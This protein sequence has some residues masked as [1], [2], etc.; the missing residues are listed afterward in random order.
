MHEVKI[1]VKVRKTRWEVI[2][3][4]GHRKRLPYNPRR[5]HCRI[6]HTYGPLLKHTLLEKTP[7]SL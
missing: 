3:D 4:C 6:C 1:S 5:S 7:K 2:L